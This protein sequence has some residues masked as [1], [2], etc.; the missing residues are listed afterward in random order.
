MG[1]VSEVVR[2]YMRRDWPLAVASRA[3][4]LDLFRYAVSLDMTR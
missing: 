4:L 3:I 1:R 2:V